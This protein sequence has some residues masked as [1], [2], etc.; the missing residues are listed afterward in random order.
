MSI[1]ACTASRARCWRRLTRAGAAVLL[2]SS[3]GGAQ[4]PVGIGV[5]EF[6]AASVKW[7][8]P[9]PAQLPLG[10]DPSSSSLAAMRIPTTMGGPGTSSPGRIHYAN[11]TLMRLIMKAYGIQSDQVNGP[12]RLISDKYMVDA[13]V[14]SGASMEQFRQMLQNLLVKRFRL[15]AGSE[16]DGQRFREAG[17]QTAELR[18]ERFIGGAKLLIIPRLELAGRFEDLGPHGDDLPVD[19]RLLATLERLRR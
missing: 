16:R 6:E 8:T 1:D 18:R 11:V 2:L 13:I 17:L 4:N 14:P 15:E 12:D 3:A 10:P 5:P 19:E 9:A 7:L